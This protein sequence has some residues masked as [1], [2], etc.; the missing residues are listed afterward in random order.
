MPKYRKFI[1]QDNGFSKGMWF[2]APVDCRKK[3]YLC[4]HC[5]KLHLVKDALVKEDF[6]YKVMVET[7]PA[8]EIDMLKNLRESINKKS[9]YHLI[10]DIVQDPDQCWPECSEI[11]FRGSLQEA[12]KECRDR[13]YKSYKITKWD[14]LK[15]EPLESPWVCD[16]FF[17]TNFPEG[18]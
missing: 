8:K 7:L 3:Y 5:Q 12:I 9:D 1:C 15:N 6:K 14:L 10:T 2:I 13:K 4:H 18:T 17:F 16:E 11:M